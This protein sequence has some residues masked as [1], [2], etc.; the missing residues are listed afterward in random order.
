MARVLGV[1][2]DHLIVPYQIHSADALVV[3]APFS[4]RPRCDGLATATPGLA[5]GVTGA[6]CG[7]VLFADPRAR[8]IGAAHAG[9]KGAL[10]GVLEATISRHGKPRRRPLRHHRGARPRHRAEE[11]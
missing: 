5:L 7:M 4:E 1:E 8:V 11:L 3:T 9:W 10:D 6:D 2:A